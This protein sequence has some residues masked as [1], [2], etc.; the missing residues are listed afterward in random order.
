LSVG[1]GM[2]QVYAN[3]LR[4]ADDVVVTG[5]STAMVNEWGEVILGSMIA[6]PITYAFFR[7]QGTVEITQNGAFNPGFASM[8]VV[9]QQ[10]PWHVAFGMAWFFL[11]F[12]AG[13]LSQLALMQPLS[14]PSCRRPQLEP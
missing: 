4:N 3:Y 11:L 2:I 8:P 14:S 6:I 13:T 1:F 5:L 7:L 12:S 9:L 10:L